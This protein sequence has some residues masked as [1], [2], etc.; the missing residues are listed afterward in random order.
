LRFF[1]AQPDGEIPIHNHFYH[2]T[3]TSLA[4]SLNATSMMPTRT[5]W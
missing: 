2:Q 1:T 5:K 3:C 4:A